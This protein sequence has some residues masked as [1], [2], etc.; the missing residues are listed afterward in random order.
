MLTSPSSIFK[1]PNTIKSPSISTLPFIVKFPLTIRTP[2][3][4]S[5]SAFL[6]VFSPSSELLF[7]FAISWFPFINSNL[8]LFMFHIINNIFNYNNKYNI[9]KK[10]Y[11]IYIV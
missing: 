10:L 2:S 1:S 4:L 8:F 7:T 11:T 3:F 6:L 9:Y 5:I